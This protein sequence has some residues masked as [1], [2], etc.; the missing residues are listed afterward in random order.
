MGVAHVEKAAGI[1]V[2]PALFVKGVKNKT[3]STVP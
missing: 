3:R 1:K 2:S